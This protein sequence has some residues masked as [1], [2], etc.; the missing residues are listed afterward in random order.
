MFDNTKKTEMVNGF[1]EAAEDDDRPFYLDLHRVIETH[2]LA[3]D[4]SAA[5]TTLNL[6]VSSTFKN[7]SR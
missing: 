6:Q 4:G 5:R 7:S 1:S 3:N 2:I